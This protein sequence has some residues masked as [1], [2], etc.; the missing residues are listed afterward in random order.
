[1]LSDL[2]AH[3]PSFARPLADLVESGGPV[4]LILLVM[5]VVAVGLVIA[6]LLQFSLAGVGRYAD[7]RKALGLVLDGREQEAVKLVR[8]GRSVQNGILLKLIHGR[9]QQGTRSELLRE[10]IERVCLGQLAA[11]RAYLRPLDMISQT[12]PLIG[13]LG[14]VLGMIE[15]FR[16]MQGAG[17]AV[18]PSVLAGGIWV[19]LLTTAV[20]LSIAIPVSA[21]VGWFD[22]IIEREQ[23]EMEA[24]VTA[25]FT[26]A[27]AE[28][29]A[30]KVVAMEPQAL[31]PRHAL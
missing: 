15:A 30:G 2:G 8:A 22:G 11:L 23:N 20:G 28:R 18:D 31:G 29:P 13:L 21:V 12:A 6:K 4:V 1:M 17:A 10:D 27:A 3:V 26:G 14:T 7:A 5:S 25:F 16:A 19:A 24:L 9:A